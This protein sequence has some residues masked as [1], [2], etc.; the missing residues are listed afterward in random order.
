MKSGTRNLPR[1]DVAGLLHGPG[2]GT[3][4]SRLPRFPHRRRQALERLRD[5]LL[6][7]PE[8]ER[9]DRLVERRYRD[10]Q[11]FDVLLEAGHGAL[12]GDPRRAAE[13]L[14]LA[15]GL[16]ALL[17]EDGELGPETGAEGLSRALCLA[18]TARRLL[19]DFEKAEAAFERAGCVPV[20]AAGRGF[21]CRALAVLRWDQGRTEEAAALLH[22]AQRRF[23]E[24]QDVREEAACLALLGLLYVDDADPVRAVSLL[25]QASQG[26]DSKRSP[27]LAAQC[28][29]GLAF[30]HA[31]A[32]EPDKA[33]SARETAHQFY[34]KLSDEEDLLTRWLEGR[35]AALAGETA[36]AAALMEAVRPWLLGRRRLPEATFA[37]IDLALL[38]I[39]SG[40]AAE[41]RGLVEE[42]KATFADQPAVPELEGL[43]EAVAEDGAAGRLDRETWGCMTLPLRMALRWQGVSLWPLPFV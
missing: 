20:S 24:A 30:C 26:I 15:T 38:W 35:V 13:I 33:R 14:S 17:D 11:L 34:G 16:A 2:K 3:A 10:P 18:G 29:L 4:P 1:P 19:S 39:E 5:E 22:H 42:L 7:L 28:C 8:E 25:R 21:F 23:A 40:R 12:P 43:L 36:E 9:Q 37:T 31:Y 32:G 41:A 6:S 27:W